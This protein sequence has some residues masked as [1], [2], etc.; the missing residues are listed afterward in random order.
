[1][2]T[3]SLDPIEEAQAKLK[4]RHMRAKSLRPP[5]KSIGFVSQRIVRKLLKT[6]EKTPNITKLKMHWQE[7]VGEELSKYCFPEK[8]TGS[9]LNRTL[10]LKVVPAAAPIIQHQSE[11]ILSR[12]KISYGGSISRIKLLQ[13]PLNTY[14]P[15]S[16]KP[17]RPL[18]SDE[19]A[20]LDNSVAGIEDQKLREA[21][22]RLGA[23]VI[24]DVS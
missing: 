12:V 4:L 21:L 6:N 9:K 5:G 22:K 19:S 8:L 14:R 17:P 20:Y 10:T 24:K 15:P 2:F 1:M 16:R 7:I 23:A 18:T 3:S 11:M 13:G